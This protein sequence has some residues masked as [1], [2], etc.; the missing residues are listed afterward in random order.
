MV[1][2]L[3]WTGVVRLEWACRSEMAP[4]F[5]NELVEMTDAAVDSSGSCVDSPY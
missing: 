3:D 5:E 2:C 1:F 4:F